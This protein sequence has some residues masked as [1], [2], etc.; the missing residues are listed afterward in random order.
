MS[1]DLQSIKNILAQNFHD[2]EQTHEQVLLY[3]NLWLEAEASLCS[4][5]YIARYNRMKK[6]MEKHGL[7]KANGELLPKFSFVK[8]L[9]YLLYISCLFF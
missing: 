7:Q 2:E 4:V 9:L 6:E 5:N 3:K 1:C 8:S